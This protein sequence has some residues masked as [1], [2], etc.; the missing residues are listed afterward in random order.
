VKSETAEEDDLQ[1]TEAVEVLAD[2]VS[3]SHRGAGSEAVA[4][5]NQ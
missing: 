2:L 5:G 1:V 4:S 3:L